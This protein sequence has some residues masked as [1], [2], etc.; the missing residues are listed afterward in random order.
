MGHNGSPYD[1]VIHVALIARSRVANYQLPTSSGT[2]QPAYC[3]HQTYWE[4]CLCYSK[5]K[6]SR[7]YFIV[8]S[9]ILGKYNPSI[10]FTARLS[11]CL[12]LIVRLFNRI[13]Y[14]NLSISWSA[15]DRVWYDVTYSPCSAWATVH[16]QLY[17]QLIWN[18]QG[19][20]WVLLSKLKLNG[21]M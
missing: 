13:M 6:Q 9:S 8:L 14:Y 10:H 1:Y 18:T 17:L 4:R 21:C 15:S 5:A 16:V 20:S 3:G 11:V 2:V 12:T 19:F 7:S